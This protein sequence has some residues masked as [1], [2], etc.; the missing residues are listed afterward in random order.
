M[1]AIGGSGLSAATSDERIGPAVQ[2]WE[3]SSLRGCRRPI[4]FKGFV[5]I[6]VCK[7]DLILFLQSKLCK[8]LKSNTEQD[9]FNE[10]GI[11]T[12]DGNR[13]LGQC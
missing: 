5:R 8:L 10:D 1:E 3:E 9:L 12:G 2:G 7:L 11:E 6:A 13:S 4:F